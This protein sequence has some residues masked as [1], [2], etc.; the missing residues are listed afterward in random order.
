MAA[1]YELNADIQ[2]GFNFKADIQR[3]VGH[4][5]KLKIGETELKADLE[6]IRDPLDAD[7]TIKVVGV[8]SCI[9]WSGQQ[10]DPIYA[11][12][13]VSNANKVI[14]DGL[15]KGQMGK[16]NV[17]LQFDY[18]DFDPAENQKVFYKSFHTDDKALSGIIHKH[19]N[20]LALRVDLTNYKNVPIPLNY[21]TALAIDPTQAKAQ[22]LH[23]A[24]SN[25]AKSVKPWGVKSS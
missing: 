5:M 19:G 25:T 7:K 1:H 24:Q 15:T 20:D 21:S 23:T 9:G 13:N 4:I 10:T 8:V 16:T 12:F 22:T 14:I 11:F 6:N 18:Y 3:S 2:Q 17:E